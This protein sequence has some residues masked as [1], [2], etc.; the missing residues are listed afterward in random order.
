MARIAVTSDFHLNPG[1]IF[2]KPFFAEGS[3]LYD[4]RPP[5]L[6][7]LLGDMRNFL[8]L[9]IKAW[10]TPEGH[11]TI[12]SLHSALGD[13]ETVDLMGNHEGRFSWL[14]ESNEGSH[15]VSMRELTIK[16]KPLP[17]HFEHGHKLT[18]WWLLRHIA[19][20]F[21]DWITTLPIFRAWWYKFCVK[22]GWIPSKYM[23]DWEG[24][25][26]PKYPDI[27]GL[28]WANVFREAQRRKVNM[29]VGHSHCQCH[30]STPHP[31]VPDVIDL[32]AK[33]WTI[34]RI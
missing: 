16:A 25:L 2:P 23:H 34:I 26:V 7:I 32:G 21:V 10:D 9:G 33:Q 8:P 30:L 18:E 17:Y 20:D 27:V 11:L 1:D 19:D 22:Q 14:R 15:F 12:Q 13:Y 6:V 24:N 4:K 28:Y 5:D 29:V 31:E 3:E